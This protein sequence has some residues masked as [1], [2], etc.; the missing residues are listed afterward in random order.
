[1]REVLTYPPGRK[2]LSADLLSIELRKLDA[3]EGK[4]IVE[5]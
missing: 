1:M 2:G 3:A 5:G 4:A